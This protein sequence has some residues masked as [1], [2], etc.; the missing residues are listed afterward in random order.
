MD[1]GYAFTRLFLILLIPNLVCAGPDFTTIPCGIIAPILDALTT[2]AGSLVMLMF[3]YGGVR[4]VFNAE[5]PSAR[6]QGKMTC[7]H[8]VIGGIL[9]LLWTGMQTLIESVTWL[10]FSGC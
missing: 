2:I 4:Y 6:S 9:V 1:K 5:N 8:A 7:I 10:D 3:L